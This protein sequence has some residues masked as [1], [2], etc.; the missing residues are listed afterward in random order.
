MLHQSHG[1]LEARI[2]AEAIRTAARAFSR[3]IGIG[4]DCASF[5]DVAEASEESLTELADIMRAAVG[6]GALP[7]DLVRYMR[8]HRE[9]AGRHQMH[10]SIQHLLEAVGSNSKTRR[11]RVGQA[12][13]A[14]WRFCFTWSGAS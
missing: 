8:T 1:D 11:P 4:A 6:H 2:T 7:T 13:R 10:N 5:L 9:E 3:H 14:S 12:S